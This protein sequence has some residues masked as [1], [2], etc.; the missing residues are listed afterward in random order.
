MKIWLTE[1]EIVPVTHARCGHIDRISRTGTKL[2]GVPKTPLNRCDTDFM[3]HAKLLTIKELAA[4]YGLSQSTIYALIST[5]P[6]FPFFNVGR[7][8][9]YVVSKELFEKWLAHRTAREKEHNI[10]VMNGA[11][12]LDRFKR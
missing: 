11:D 10:G 12:L 1:S 6:S 3:E 5:E 8:K 4:I 7:K 9:K 2:I